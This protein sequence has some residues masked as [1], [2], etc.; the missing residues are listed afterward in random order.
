MQRI[1]QAWR[2]TP[3][4]ARR[5]LVLIIGT[6]I[7]IAG[8]LMLVLPGPGWAAIFLGLAVLSTEFD[9]ADKIRAA[10]TRRFKDVIDK[11]FAKKKR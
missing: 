8:M 9:R 7:I 1:K 5:V 4:T 6:L 11:A 10:I 2:R 3:R